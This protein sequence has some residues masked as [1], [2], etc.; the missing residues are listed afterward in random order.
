VEE[1]RSSV[2][3]RKP[4]SVNRVLVKPV[5]TKVVVNQPFQLLADVTLDNLAP[6][7]TEREGSVVIERYQCHALL[8]SA[9]CKPIREKHVLFAVAHIAQLH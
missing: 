1:W 4:F 9:S 6:S 5:F 2:I 3:S 7:R 8:I